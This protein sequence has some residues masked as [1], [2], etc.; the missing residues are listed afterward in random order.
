MRSGRDGY[1]NIM[2]TILPIFYNKLFLSCTH[3]NFHYYTI[4]SS[5]T[6]SEQV[7]TTSKGDTLGL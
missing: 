6:D 5:G 3:I 2:T 7:K 1:M 4:R